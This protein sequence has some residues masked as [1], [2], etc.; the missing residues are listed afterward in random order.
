MCPTH[1]KITLEIFFFF[2]CFLF[3]VFQLL[4]KQQFE[5]E[6]F[7]TPME[8]NSIQTLSSSWENW[9]GFEGTAKRNEYWTKIAPKDISLLPI[10]F[11]GV[12]IVDSILL[13]IFGVNNN[14][15]SPFFVSLCLQ[16]ELMGPTG[17]WQLIINTL[18]TTKMVSKQVFDA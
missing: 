3:S 5:K 13:S 9:Y 17:M 12:I 11:F 8:H 10:L 1:A 15:L 16:F 7:C 18:L 2:C 4:S 6:I 14:I